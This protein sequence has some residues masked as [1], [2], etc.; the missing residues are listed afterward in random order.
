VTVLSRS[1]IYK[2]FTINN[3]RNTFILPIRVRQREISKQ[4]LHGT[5]HTGT[6]KQT[7]NTWS[8]SH[9]PTNSTRVAYHIETDN[10]QHRCTLDGHLLTAHLRRSQ[11]F[12][13]GSPLVIGVE[14]TENSKPKDGRR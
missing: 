5:S 1:F 14:G 11:F 9:I 13:A 6:Q 2:A 12:Y 10:T 4:P 3:N 8:T 7:D